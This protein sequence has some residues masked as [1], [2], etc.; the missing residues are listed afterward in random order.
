MDVL[1]E[2]CARL[3]AGYS[4]AGQ[5]KAAAVT[6]FLL[7]FSMVLRHQQAATRT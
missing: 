3:M 4:S 5:G 7:Y 1:L 2:G 6:S